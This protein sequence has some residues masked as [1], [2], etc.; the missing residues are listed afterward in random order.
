MIRE[1]EF[2]EMPFFSSGHSSLQSLLHLWPS[3]NETFLT[4]VV[5][6]DIL[7]YFNFFSFFGF[8]LSIQCSEKARGCLI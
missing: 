8:E 4:A 5:N 6:V 7:L 3:F 1:P 2:T